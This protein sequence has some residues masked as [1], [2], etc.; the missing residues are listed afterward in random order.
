VS[1]VL[2]CSVDVSAWCLASVGEGL[3][4]DCSLRYRVIP[5]PHFVAQHDVE[6]GILNI[7]VNVV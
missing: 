5:L 4:F 2:S 1:V 3:Q 7:S 6:N